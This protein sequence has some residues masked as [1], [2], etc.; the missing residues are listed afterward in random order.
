MVL[1]VND[2][3][4]IG[5]DVVL[6]SS[7]KIWLSTQ[8]QMKDLGEVQCILGS[9]VLIDCKNRKLT[10]SQATYID[11]LL[12]KHVIQ[13]EILLSQDQCLKTPEEKECMQV[14]PLCLCSGQ[15]YVY[16]VMY[17]VGYL[18]YNGYGEQILVKSKPRTM[19]N[20]QTYTQ[21]SQENE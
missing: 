14:I 3:L 11:K 12:V 6:L 2:I 15:P 21:V 10:L 13:D 7:I 19:D 18:L 9:K 17:Q 1:Y 20:C 4:F 8:F 16:D 5:N